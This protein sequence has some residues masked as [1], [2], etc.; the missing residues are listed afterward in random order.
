MRRPHA[1]GLHVDG[2]YAR[3]GCWWPVRVT[4]RDRSEIQNL[5]G[6]FASFPRSTFPLGNYP[7]PPVKF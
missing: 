4:L 1:L 2:G 3:H 6:R 5:T 7:K